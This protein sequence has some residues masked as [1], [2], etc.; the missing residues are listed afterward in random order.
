MKVDLL[1]FLTAFIWGFAFVAQ[2]VGMSHMGPFTF[3]GIRFS[4]G[5]LSLVPFLIWQRRKNLDPTEFRLKAYWV[6]IGLT[7]LALFLGAALQQV[8]LVGTT[9]GKGGFITGLYVTLVP[10]L[11]LLWG[12]R[13]HTAHW[14]GALLAVVGLYLLSVGEGW[15]VSTYDLV[16]L[17]GAFVW[18]V[19]VHLIDKYSNP[20]GPLRLAF[21]QAAVCGLLG[22]VAAVIFEPITLSGIKEGLW[23]LLYGSILSVGVAFTLQIT[24]QRT[25]NPSH[26]VI[27]LSLEGVF[28][29]L[30]GWLVLNEVMAPRGLI[31][32]G[33][34]L[35]GTLISQFFGKPRKNTDAGDVNPEGS[36]TERQI[37]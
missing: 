7:G 27:I 19:H 15:A 18:A 9:A 3:T 26:V 30:G 8:G 25:A 24:A 31:G 14:A 36:A 11:A 6:P 17:A 1:L 29:A 4:L 33:L 23:T 13:T 2:R 12:V 22:L 10:L 21:F 32:A 37:S 35:T 5:A 34:I 20:V 16:L 28:A